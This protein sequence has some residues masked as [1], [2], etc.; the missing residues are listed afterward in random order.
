MFATETETAAESRPHRSR[1]LVVPCLSAFVVLVATAALP[2]LGNE[3]HAGT[4]GALIFIA[5]TPLPG[6]LLAVSGSGGESMT[7]PR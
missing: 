5:L 4:S 1:A 3:P 6:V 7:G 2:T